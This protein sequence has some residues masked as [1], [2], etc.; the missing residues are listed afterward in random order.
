MNG[1]NRPEAAEIAM[2]DLASLKLSES[3]LRDSDQNE[4]PTPL[5][6]HCGHSLG[7]KNTTLV[8]G[9]ENVSKKMVW[10]SINLG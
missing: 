7:Q 6:A 1:D 9:I 10:R 5:P 2:S 4:S 3:R 8:G